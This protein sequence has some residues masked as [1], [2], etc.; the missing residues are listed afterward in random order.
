MTI[1]ELTWEEL[2]D[3]YKKKTGQS[4][5]IRPMDDIFEWA[6]RQEEIT[7]TKDGSLI[8]NK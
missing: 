4:A 3:F 5:K 7:L 2:A 8:F 1:K 6:E